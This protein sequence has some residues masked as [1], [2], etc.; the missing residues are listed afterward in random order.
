MS[1]THDTTTTPESTAFET[2]TLAEPPVF[3][4]PLD[5]T[6]STSWQRA[7]TER[8]RGGWVNPAERMVFLENSN[9]PHRVLFALRDRTLRARCSCAGHR[10][11][12]WCAHVAHL[13]WRWTTGRL[14]VRHLDTGRD[15]QEPPSWLLIDCE[16]SEQL[17]RLSPAELDAFL[18]CEIGDAGVRQWARERDRAP[19][20]IGNLLASARQKLRP[21]R[22]RAG[23]D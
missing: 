20:T 3:S 22:M 9:H 2:D 8:E 18:H 4:T 19:G 21:N 1:K 10:H 6:L 12:D 17:D 14:V 15:Y 13:W 23:G 16:P 7:Q 5:W 11:R